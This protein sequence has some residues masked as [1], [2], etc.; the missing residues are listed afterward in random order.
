MAKW[1][2]DMVRAWDTSPDGAA[3]HGPIWSIAT[4]GESTM[5]ACR[6]ILCMTHELAIADPLYPFLRNLTGLNLFTG[7]NNVTMTCDPKHIFK[8]GF[9]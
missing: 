2:V 4:D 9:T 5:R 8:R 3:I 7:A 6:F 1:V